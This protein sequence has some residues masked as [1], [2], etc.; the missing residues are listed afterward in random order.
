MRSGP[1]TSCAIVAFALTALAGCP[2][3][4]H[5]P[6]RVADKGAVL[7]PDPKGPDTIR[8]TMECVNGSFDTQCFAVKCTASPG[9]PSDDCASYAKACID[10]D[11]H[12]SGT[13]QG[14]T[15][16]EPL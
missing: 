12:W 5:T 3:P 14:G 13:S 15:C 10:A 7:N 2:G 11:L 1:A 8:R 9:G 6:T 16:S 4:R